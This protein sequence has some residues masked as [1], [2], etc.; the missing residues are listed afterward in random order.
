MDGFFTLRCNNLRCRKQLEHRAV[1]TTCSHIFCTNCAST[2]QSNPPVGG[3]R[4]CPACDTPLTAPD[5]VVITI[6][7]PTD[8]YK[9]SVLSGLNPTV[10][11]EICG[12]GL[13]FWSYQVTQEVVYQEYT[14]KNLTEK[15]N[16]LNTQ[17]D[18]FIHEAN[19]EIRSLREKI[20]LMT[21]AEEEL[22]RKNHELMEG[23]REKGRKLAQTQ[24]LYDKLKRRTLISQV[25]HAA[26]ESVDN[27]LL[28]SSQQPPSARH[29]S[30]LQSLIQN[31]VPLQ[32]TQGHRRQLEAMEPSFMMTGARI[33]TVHGGGRA[34]SGSSG[35]RMSPVATQPR[36]RAG[37][38]HA[39]SQDP[40]ASTPFGSQEHRQKIDATPQIDHNP[41]NGGYAPNPIF[42]SNRA[43]G[44]RSPLGGLD[45]NSGLGRRQGGLGIGGKG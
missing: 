13:G 6:L 20:T 1:V 45:T 33:G 24:D 21:S 15:Y 44:R 8:D 28:M 2:L 14:A 22:R 41:R 26:S 35:G 43:T 30:H 7:N 16:S 23:W 25:R 27:T 5:D 31:S 36:Q 4:I 10:I 18:N 32:P 40:F 3:Q 19:A 12:R 42:F 34:R 37:G 11:M 38:A 39:F 9:T 17:L 29:P